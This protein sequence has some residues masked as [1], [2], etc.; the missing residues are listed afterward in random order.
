MKRL[1]AEFKVSFK[2]ELK[3]ELTAELRTTLATKEEMVNITARLDGLATKEEMEKFRTRLDDHID[4]ARI[5]HQ[6][7][8]ANAVHGGASPF[9]STPRMWVNSAASPRSSV[10]PRG[11]F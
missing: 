5:R 9:S 11:R 8:M 4:E 10:G 1:L 2:E 7:S 6:A 3:T